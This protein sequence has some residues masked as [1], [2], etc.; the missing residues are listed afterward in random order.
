VYSPVYVKVAGLC[1]RFV[2]NVAGVSSDATVDEGVSCQAAG[3]RERLMALVAFIAPL[4]SGST[5]FAFCTDQ[6]VMCVT[7]IA[8]I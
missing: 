5:S 1:K 8:F 7:V 4:P 3:V 6:L 2:A